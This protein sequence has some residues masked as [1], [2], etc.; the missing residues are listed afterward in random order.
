MQ[1]TKIFQN[2]KT[3]RSNS[4]TK[5]TLNKWALLSLLWIHQGKRKRIY[6]LLRAISSKHQSKIFLYQIL[7]CLGLDKWVIHQL[8]WYLF[9]LLSP[10]YFAWLYSS[11]FFCFSKNFFTA[12]SYFIL[13]ILFEY[14]FFILLKHQWIKCSFF[15]P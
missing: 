8:P 3:L 14:M 7:L 13:L 1:K 9:Y 11:S 4:I 2:H 5:Q 12:L 6:L 15:C 10:E